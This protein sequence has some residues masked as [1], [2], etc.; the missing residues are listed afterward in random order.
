VQ[1]VDRPPYRL[2]TRDDGSVAIDVEARDWPGLLGAAALALSDACRPLGVFDTWTARRVTAR[3]K[4]HEEVLA[5]WL[6]TLLHDAAASGFLPAL[7]EVERAE[8]H[9]A[10]GIHRGGIASEGDGPPTRRLTEVVDGTLRVEAGADGAPW[11]A[12]FVAR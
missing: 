3:G 4:T 6:A 12:T 9:R 2:T 8:E 10:S 11:R 7:A 1:P 5:R